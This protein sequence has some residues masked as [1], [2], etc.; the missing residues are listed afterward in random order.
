MVKKY[1]YIESAKKEDDLQIII[2]LR[3]SANQFFVLVKE[4]AYARR[5]TIIFLLVT[6]LARMFY[7]PLFIDSRRHAHKR[8]LS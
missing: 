8:N 2:I 7:L 5:T 1:I 3:A 4:R 6:F